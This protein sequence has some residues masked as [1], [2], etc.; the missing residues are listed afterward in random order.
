MAFYIRKIATAKWEIAQRDT[1]EATVLRYHADAVANDL[2]TSNNCLSI[3]KSASDKDEDLNP[4]ILVNS[5]MGDNIKTLHLLCIPEEMLSGFSLLQ[6]PGDTVITECVDQHFNLS[7]ESVNGLLSFAN[8]VVLDILAKERAAGEGQCPLIL[9]VFRDNQMKLITQWIVEKKLKLNALK[10]QQLDD[11]DKYWHR[12][13]P[14][15]PSS[16]A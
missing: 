6:E 12:C 3:W 9:H 5:L 13:P 16:K 15:Y 14:Q 11:L 1:G 7:V 2:R 4:L 10:P 8:H